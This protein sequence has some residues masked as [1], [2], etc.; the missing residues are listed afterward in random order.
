MK[1]RKRLLALALVG[2]MSLGM[3]LSGCG[4][5]SAQS[6]SPSPSASAPAESTPAEGFDMAVCIASEP[7]TIDPALNSAV[8]GAIMTQHMFEGLMKWVDSGN[9]VNEKGNMNYAALAAGQAESYEKTDNGDG[10]VTYTFKIRSDAKWSDGQPVTANDFVYS[11]Q[12]LANPLTAA[13]YCY[14]IDMVQGYAAVNAGEADPTTLGV[15]APDESTFVVNLTYDCPYF[16]EICAFPAAF[17]VRQDIIEAYGDTWTTDDNSSHYISN[18]PWKLAEWVHDSYIKMVPN[19]YHYDAANLGPNSLTFQLMEDQNSMLAAYR[20]GDLQFIEDM[21]VDEIAGLLASGELNIVDYIG[22]Y[23]VCYQTQAAP[24]DNALVRQAF[25]LA[26]DSKYIVEQVTQTGQVPATG[27]V[28]A[29]IYDA[30]PNGD[31][32]RTVGG[33]YWDAPVDDATYQANCEKARQLLAEAGY[34]NGEGFPTV[35][36]LYN[37][38]D[39]HKAVGEA[40]QQMWQE[41]LGVTVQLQN[42][43]WNAFL[44]TRKKGE[45]QIARNGWI[46]DYNDPCSFLDMWYTGGGNNDAQYSNPEYDAMIDAAKATSD[47]AERMSYFHKAE[48]III[49]QDWALGPIYFYTQ[50]YMMADDISGAFYTPLGYFIY[51][52][53]TKG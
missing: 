18:G 13:D 10:T 31:D 27:F 51:G 4:G 32:F 52:Y 1:N 20:S 6:P 44:E 41:E 50:K 43:E 30:D 36:Y 47:P 45:Y 48:D 11:W 28:P 22:T 5:T 15:S 38:S 34:P 49:G 25:T 14:M 24:F 53:C 39:A 3:L 46:A 9:P 7:Q 17:P 12:R 40:L 33:D 37:T 29:G 23:Y 2:V 21:P 35:T 42:Q 26:I 16:L 19:E 8:D